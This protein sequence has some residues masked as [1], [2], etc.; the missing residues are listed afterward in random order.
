MDL[1]T[2]VVSHKM[3]AKS[4]GIYRLDEFKNGFANM[5]VGSM[6]EL[7]AIIPSL[8]SELRNSA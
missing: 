6:K 2:L 7:K 8:R 5:G 3:N 4:M 1:V